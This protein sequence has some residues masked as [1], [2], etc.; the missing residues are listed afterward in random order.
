MRIYLREDPFVGQNQGLSWREQGLWPC[1]WIACPGAERSP[2]VTAFRRSF[3]VQQAAVVRIHVSADERYDL[4]LDGER[5]GRGPERGAPHLWFYESYDLV[6]SP[7]AHTLVARVWSLGEQ[8]AQA[9]MSV[10]PG[11]LLAAE[12]EWL[13]VLGT[14]LAP[15]EALLL[16]GYS[17]LFPTTA[18]W[19]G[20][21]VQ[22]DGTSFPWGFERGAGSGWLAALTLKPAIGRFCDWELHSEHLLRPATLPPMAEPPVKGMLVRCARSVPD[23]ETSR[24]PVR[25]ADHLTAEKWQNILDGKGAIVL[26]PHTIRQV[27]VDLND[28]YVAFP[29][30]VASGGAGGRIRLQWAESLYHPETLGG[31]NTRRERPHKGNRDELEGKVFVGFGDVFLPDGGAGRVFEPLWWH[32]GRYLE[33]FVE[34]GEQPLT[35]ERFALREYRYPLELE[36]YFAAGDPRLT[37]ILPNLVRGMQMCAN[38][39]YF[40]TPYYEELQYAGDTRLEC[41]L[42][43]VMTRDESLPRKALRLFDASRLDSGLT[44]SRYPSRVMQIIPPFALW[45]VLMVRDYAF[46]RGDPE[47]LA[48]LMPGVRATIE[49]FRRFIGPDGLMH[50]PEGW[51][52]LDWVPAW[53]DDAGVPPDGHSGVSG[54]LNW[55]LVYVLTRYV[56]LEEELGEQELA[57]RAKRWAGDL[58]AAAHFSFW[59]EERGLLADDLAH[60]HFSE[61]SQCL[62]LLSG[63]LGWRE[64]KIASGLL[65]DPDLDRATVYFSHY[66]FETYRRLG[67]VDKL[68]ERLEYWYDLRRMGLKTVLESPEPSRSDSHAWSTHPLFHYFATILGIRP[69]GLGF[70]KVIVHPQLGG[71]PYA[72]AELVHPDGGVIRVEVDARENL[73]DVRVDLPEG[74]TGLLEVGHD[75]R[76]LCSG[77]NEFDGLPFIWP[78]FGESED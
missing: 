58:A 6:L 13:P 74:V 59:D 47:F 61:H 50:S 11:F 23:A 1:S 69:W 43:Y 73:Y 33:L 49:G 78:E 45:W 3:T 54:V 21:R 20:H 36:S 4:Y 53:D 18:H 14:G 60:T 29:E 62:A 76:E 15:W 68:L 8:G 22:V 37:D 42:T 64:E 12:G 7:G 2:F 35:L 17:Y 32:A 31:G 75:V 34:T 19:R 77:P 39:T 30:I 41:L 5:I 72:S 57:E 71:L 16:G 48:S 51:N 26:P 24:V 56:E 46:W 52:T 38:E 63:L 44:Q 9:Q 67:R 27:I 25:L 70:K 40:D 65:E 10:H 66:L 55:H 28:Y